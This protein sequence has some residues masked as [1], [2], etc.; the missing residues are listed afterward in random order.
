MLADKVLNKKTRE[1]RIAV[2][3]GEINVIREKPSICT[4][5][6]KEENYHPVEILCCEKLRLFFGGEE[7]AHSETFSYSSK[8]LAV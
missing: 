3:I 8:V 2:A 4:G 1:I 5:T 7:R 6:V